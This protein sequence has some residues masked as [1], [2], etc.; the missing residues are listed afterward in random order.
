MIQYIPI[1][2]SFADGHDLYFINC[3]WVHSHKQG[4]GNFQH[5]GMGN[6]LLKAAEADARALGA[7]G[8]VT[9][10]LVIPAF[11][12]ASWFRKHGYK[13]VDRKGIQALLWKP[14]TSDAVP[15]KW[16]RNK[17]KPSLEKDKFTVTAFCNGW[18]PAQNMTVERAKRA[19]ADPQFAGKVVYREVD[20][21]EREEIKKLG[22]SDA[23]F[24]DRKKV[25]IGPPP[26]YDKIHKLISKRVNRLK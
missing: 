17:Y 21:F 9:W 4:R 8:I 23:L 14:F 19:A 25:W 11:M 6:A 5:R 18:C 13:T 24:I 10:G 26:S 1:E 22:V 3:I 15:P 20:T 2:Y 7:K 16:I 12:R